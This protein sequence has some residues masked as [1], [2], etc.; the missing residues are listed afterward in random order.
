[1]LVIENW[2]A[3]PD[4]EG[5]YEVSDLGRVRSVVRNAILATWLDQDGYPAVTVCKNGR[6]SNAKLHRWVALAFHGSKRN[7]LHREVAH[8]DNDRA[9]PLASNL[10]W[11]SHVENHF[12]RRAHGTSPVGERHPRAK[13]TEKQVIEIRKRQGTAPQMAERYGVS[14]HTIYDIWQGKR[15]A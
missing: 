14:R 10:Q 12:H 2:R 7:A 5:L 8:L 3:V 15:W 9:N 4:F 1:M 13:L 11:V 6:K